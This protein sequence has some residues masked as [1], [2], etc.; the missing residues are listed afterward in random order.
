MVMPS[1]SVV[2]P[3][4]NEARRLEALIASLRAQDYRGTTELVFVDGDSTD[5]SM[6]ILQHAAA[7]A[8]TGPSIVIVHNPKRNIPTAMNLGIRAATGEI[9]VRV[10]GHSLPSP[11]FV[12]ALVGYLVIHPGLQVVYGRLEVRPS[13]SNHTGNALAAAFTHWLSGSGSGYRSNKIPESAAISVDTVPYGAFM[14]STWTVVGGF[15]ENLLASEDYD[16]MLRVR[17]A[18]GSVTLLPA[19]AI[20]YYARSTFAATWRNALRAGFWVGVLLRKHRKV[21]SP[22]KIAPAAVL[23]GFIVILFARPAMALSGLAL[24]GILMYVLACRH[25]MTDGRSLVE[26]LP[27]ALGWFLMHLGYALGSLAGLVRGYR[28]MA[29]TED[30]V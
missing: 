9:I 24:Y 7:E 20:T 28:A 6:M 2:V 10:D 11:N 23:L 27:E 29:G 4:Y 14:R 21:V 25:S 3:V 1:V 15:D 26:A 22:R 12:S 8:T 13:Y 17:S 18:G 19:L 16:F 5:E 30:R